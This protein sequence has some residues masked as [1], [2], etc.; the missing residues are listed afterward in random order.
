MS[1]PNLSA[2]AVR[3]RAVTLFFL[4]LAVIAGAY[5]FLALG[6]AEDPQFSVRVMAVTV[7]WPGATAEEIKTQVV[8]R[9]EKRIQEVESLYRIETTIRPGSANLQIEFEEYVPQAHIPQLLYQVRKRML[10]EA[11]KLPAGVIGPMVNEDL[12]DVYFNLIALTAPGMP[13]RELTREA[14]AIRDRLQRIEGVH[15][16]TVMGERP[17]RV[18][19]EFDTARLLNLGIAPQAVFDAIAASNRLLPAGRM[20]TVGPHLYLRLDADLSDPARLAAVPIRI[21]NRL[22][23]L[24]DIAKIHRGYEDPPSFLVRARGQDAVLLGVVMNNG[25]NGMALGKRLAAFVEAER[26]ALPLGMSM[27]VLTNQ[28]DAI[29]S[30]INLFQVKFLVAVAVVVVI[31]MLAI[32]LRAGLIVGIAVPLTLGITFLTMKLMGIDLDRIT[33]GALILSLGLLVDDA[34]ISVEMMLVKIEEGWDR[35]RTAAHAWSVTAAPMLFGTLVTVAGFL[36]IGFARSGVKEYAGN[37]FW[38]M[39]IALAASWLVAV[40][41]VPYLGVK[42]LPQKAASADH[43]QDHGSI[44]QTPFYRRLR[45]FITGCVTYRKTVVGGTVALLVIAVLGMIF[46]VQKQFFPGSDRPEALISVFMPPGSS[47]AATDKTVRKI[48]AILAPLPE[49]KTLSTYTGAGAPRFFIT[50]N[51]EPANPGFAKVIAVAHDAEGRNRIMATMR[52]HIAKGEFPEARVRVYRLLY[53]PPVI[54]PVTFRVIGPD[55]VV[56]RDIAHQV[57]E[58]MVANPHMVDPHLEWDGRIPSLHL[59]MDEERLRLLGLTPQEVAQQLQFQLDG[60]PVTQVRA[61]IRTVDVVARGASNG[62]RLD[63]DHL[64][65]LEILTR[66]GRKLPAR[67]LGRIEVRFEDPVIMRYNRE[68]Y[69]SVQGDISG[70]Q[71]NDVSA[72]V[73]QSLQ[74]IRATLPAGYRIDVGGSVEQSARSNVSIEK[75]QPAMV[76]FMLI[77]VMLQMRSFS[78]TFIVIA[79]A[80]LGLIGAVLALLLFNQPFGFVALLGLTG[81]AGILMRNTLILTQQVSDNFEAGMPALEGVVEAAVQRARPVVVTGLA[82]VLAFVP[83]TNDSFWGPL[84]YVLIGGV[85]VG[86]AITLLFVPAL[87]ALWFRLQAQQP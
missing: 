44:Y 45:A 46:L 51:P 23:K 83:L 28:A 7:A 77:F 26:K 48:E 32:G 3:E 57:R 6:R 75:L 72:A 58:V 78:G 82:A 56:L 4:L 67:Q 11:D 74:G 63:A 87:Y 54:W 31:S 37:I 81:L 2:L 38:V 55:P 39:G 1:F 86:T 19:V 53:G 68:P 27:E 85:A 36:P 76:A 43:G 47:I 21:G 33:L 73:W 40:V 10:E 66:E 70:A 35:V 17:E 49:V 20:E 29:E 15:K 79:T 12:S 60:V 50:A 5:A 24:A 62:H 71:P 13:M 34:I 64:G 59:S 69:I 18:F 42:M 22:F 61:D 9:L 52:E 65:D 16:A 80:P 14:E 8:D 25:E 30:A 84:A 41:F